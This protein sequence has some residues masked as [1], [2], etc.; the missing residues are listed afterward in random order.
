MA[1][2]VARQL[3]AL[4]RDALSLSARMLST[5]LT[6]AATED[7]EPRFLDAV[8]MY[9]DRAAKYSSASEE[10][11]KH[12]RST[13]C[14][15]SVSF[16]VEKDGKTVMI[17]GY[18]SQH[19]RH[20]LPCKGGIRFSSEVDLQEVKALAALMTYKCAVVDVPFGGGKGG[21]M[22]NPKDWTEA[23][24]ERITRRFT[25]ELCQKNFIGPG[26]DVPAPDVGTGARE[27][28]WIADTYRNFHPQD[29]SGAACVTGK[30]LSL[31]GVRGRT[32]ATGLGVY[33][34]IR[35]FLS[36]PEVQQKINHHGKVEGSTVII[37]G[38]GN[39]GY[40]AAKFFEANGAKVIG[41]IEHDVAAYN[42]NGINVEE[43]S[44]WRSEHGSFAGYSG[45]QIVETPMAL[46]EAECD[47]L[48]P[49]AL[50]RQIGLRNAHK[51]KA[52]LV[53]EAANGP[54]TPG[55]DEVLR[56]NGTI[57]VPDLLLNAGG[58]CVSYFEWAKNLSHLRFGRMNKRWDER[59]KAQL[60]T[61]V[62]GNAG[63]PLSEVERRE[64]IHGA[65]EHELV[66]SGLEDTMIVA[67]N[68]TRQTANAKD[69]DYRTAA[70]TN[71]INK[72]AASLAGSGSIFTHT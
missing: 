57:I 66:Y 6:N 55:A 1:S 12:I 35:E 67:C 36:F 28:G 45:V 39:V 5:G 11:L 22:I 53:G 41:I 21:I 58:V 8:G 43:L 69:I 32:E 29:V 34:G 49:A 62:E 59:S 3:G 13:D 54:V 25:L 56:K 48:V 26:V 60:L 9:F 17:K 46:L 16:P 70:M 4:R 20:R 50:E 10:T 37:Q 52:K 40:W 15:L 42:K 64:L 51:I 24:L 31:G 68:E 65:E 2:L 38:F 47:I 23:E 7:H 30:S 19:S 27:M 14:V 61:L 33:Y 44:Q 18:R 63:R 71:S 72:I